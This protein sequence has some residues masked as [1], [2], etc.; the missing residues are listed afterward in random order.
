MTY[1]TDNLPPFI[2]KWKDSV[3]N[4]KSP[5]EIAQECYHPDAILKGTVWSEA[6]QGHSD[7]TRYFEHFT[8]GKNNATVTFLTIKT[9]PTG[10]YAGEYVFRWTDDNVTATKRRGPTIPLSPRRSM[11]AMLSLFITPRFLFRR[12]S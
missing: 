1:S 4:G 3:E 9:S 12:L 11:D 7:I 2:H 10:S 5:Q 8:A 6:V